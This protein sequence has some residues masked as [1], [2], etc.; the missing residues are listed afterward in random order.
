MDPIPQ[1]YVVGVKD[2]S[3]YMRMKSKDIYLYTGIYVLKLS[4]TLNILHRLKLV[5]ACRV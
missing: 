2:V 5:N 3:V 4:Q 1:L